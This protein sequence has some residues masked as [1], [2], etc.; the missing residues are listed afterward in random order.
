MRLASAL[1]VVV[2]FA[3]REGRAADWFDGRVELH[4][5]AESQAR[6]IS[7]KFEQELD[8]AQWYNVLNLELEADLL[9]SGFGPIDL[10]SAYVRAEGRYDAIYSEG[11]GLFH[12]IDTYGDD[13]HRLPKRLRDAQDVDYA[14]VTPTGADPVPRHASEKPAPLASEGERRGIPD[15]DIFFRQAGADNVHG[16]ADDPGRYANA[17]IL[18]YRFALKEFRGAESTGPTQV[19]GPW[20]PKN[21]ILSVAMGLDRANPFRGRIPSTAIASGFDGVA[22]GEFDDPMSVRFFTDDPQLAGFTAE[23]IARFQVDPIDRTSGIG[24]ALFAQDTVITELSRGKCERAGVASCVVGQT[25]PDPDVTGMYTVRAL[26]EFAPAPLA[27]ATDFSLS[28]FD[29]SG[30]P[31][32]AFGG[33]FS[34]IIPCL[35]PTEPDLSSAQRGDVDPVDRI[36]SDGCIPGSFETTTVGG[37]TSF[38]RRVTTARNVR[39]TGGSVEAPFR[40]APDLAVADAS[41]PGLLRAQGL[42]IPSVGLRRALASGDLDSLPFNVSESERA[43]NRG[44]SQ[45]RTKELKEAYLDLETLDQRLWMRLGLQHIVWGKT[46][47]FRTTDQFNPQDLALSS[48]PSLEESRIALWSARFVYSLYDVG[49]L[50]DV[51]LELAMNLDEFEPNDLGACG[52]PYTADFVCT[53]T[54]GIASHSYLGAGIAGIDRPD[55]P[56]EDPSDLEIGGRIEWR[57]DRFSFALTDFYGYSD[58]PYADAIF[59]YD[60]SVDV[61]TGRPV[62]AVLPGQTLGRCASGGQIAP[63]PV[64]RADTNQAGIAYSTSFASH[65]YSVTPAQ[66]PYAEGPG[67]VDLLPDGSPLDGSTAVRGGIG[68]DPDCL[69]PGG[70]PGY[71]N[72][73]TLDP[74]SLVATTNA[75]EFASSNQQL[76]AWSCISTVGIAAALEPG[77]CAWTFFTSPI[78]LRS[79]ALPVAEA[80]GSVFAGNPDGPTSVRYMALVHDFQKNASLA[81][82]LIAFPLASLNRLYNDP[83]APLDRNGNGVVDN[84]PGCADDD[85]TTP[86]DLGGF[87]GFDTRTTRGAS[88]GVPTLDNSLTNEQRA[89]LGC[90]PFYGTRCDTSA[91]ETNTLHFPQSGEFGGID[92]LNME[93]SVLVQSWLGVEGTRPGQTLTDNRPQPGTIGPLGAGVKSGANSSTRVN[94]PFLGGPVCTRFVEHEGVLKLPGCRGIASLSVVYDDPNGIPGDAD[95]EPTSVLVAFEAGYLPSVDGCILGDLVRRSSGAVVPVMAVGASPEL[96]RELAACSDATTRRAVPERLITGFN[97]Q[98]NPITAPNPDCTPR[99]FGGELT[100][101]GAPRRVF[102]CASEEVTLAELPL[103]HPSAGCVDSPT[104]PRGVASCF[105]WANRDLVEEFFDGSAQL[106]QNE[107]AA[108]SYNFL[109]FL[110]ISSC[111]TRSVDLDGEDHEGGRAAFRDDP[112]CFLPTAPY[113][114]GRCSLS[115]PQLCANVKSFLAAVGVPRNTVRAAGNDRFG[116][117]TFIWH[118]GGEVVLRYDQR[119]VLGFA[120]DFA[121]DVT[122]TSWGIE[123]TWIED[124]PFEDADDPEGITKAD[125][126]NLTV[127]VD[128]PTFIHFLNPNRTFLFNTQWFVNYVPEATDSFTANGPVNVFFTFAV[129]TGY[130]QDRMIPELLTVYEIDSRSG[131]IMPSLQYRMTESLSVTVGVLWFFGRTQL[132]DMPVREVAPVVNRTGHNAYRVGVENGLSGIRKR[133]EVFM[134]LRYS[135]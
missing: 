68:S 24:L 52:E 23:Q 49:P 13:A 21:R 116:R 85:P 60:R 89:L 110:A 34:G 54:N 80:F 111:D 46:E 71:A 58:V 7:E 131:G 92:F 50:D 94:E 9:P 33:D 112:E 45:E 47:I 2:S 91:R 90:G 129:S 77:A 135:F 39:Y 100:I 10:L 78:D 19:L 115:T 42:Y 104:N 64:N 27:G 57:W 41:N 98:Q 105:E 69:R 88:P 40:P 17:G 96:R 79:A 97:A 61:L 113:R 106:F 67:G 11:F 84:G 37:V 53:L 74:A 65:P 66:R 30:D 70:A 128:R 15:Y 55:S 32:A 86:C 107:L 101:N 14:G 25:F 75:L 56:W 44:S 126:Y 31:I 102:I 59:Y 103:I 95:D 16:T 63:D 134:R 121:E 120:T 3:A 76:F 62:V 117:R 123:F 51:R 38:G 26:N 108:F 132:T 5:H 124:V 4:G 29:S 43:F 118:S 87:D 81:G 12:S 109:M 1:F 114:P 127:S 28:G 35:D 20:L 130:F 82:P 36:E 125:Q 83:Q 22:G 8:L 18:D 119:N 48:L 133:D 122:K 72:A 99:G 6:A 93:A 73:F